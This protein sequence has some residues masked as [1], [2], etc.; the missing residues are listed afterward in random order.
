MR[1]G[2]RHFL[3]EIRATG[4]VKLATFQATAL[5][6]DARSRTDTSHFAR[7]FPQAPFLRERLESLA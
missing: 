1:S 2:S 3:K 4:T 7:A 6:T 5:E